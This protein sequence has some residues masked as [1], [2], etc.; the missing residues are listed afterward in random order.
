MGAF[1]TSNLGTGSGSAQTTSW[2]L[3]VGGT[4]SSSAQTTSWSSV[5]LTTTTDFDF[6]GNKWEEAGPLLLGGG[7]W[8]SS[9]LNWVDFD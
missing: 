9:E 5:Q 3:T 6:V 4:G 2:T 7:Y 8:E 1:T